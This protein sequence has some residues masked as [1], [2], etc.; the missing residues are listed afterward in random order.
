MNLALRNARALVLSASS[1]IG[2]PY[3]LA[4]L[5]WWVTFDAWSEKASKKLE[6]YEE[7]PEEFLY[8]L[9]EWVVRQ[10]VDQQSGA[11]ATALATIADTAE[12]VAGTIE[13]VKEVRDDLGQM[14]ADLPASVQKYVRP[15][16]D[17]IIKRFD[18]FY[19][20]TYTP[21]VE[22]LGIE[23]EQNRMNIERHRLKI[24]GLDLTI[25]K[26]PVKIGDWEAFEPAE[27]RRQEEIAEDTYTRP[28][29]RNAEVFTRVSSEETEKIVQEQKQKEVKIKPA[30]TPEYLTY[31]A[32]NTIVEFFRVQFTQVWTNFENMLPNAFEKLVDRFEDMLAVEGSPKMV[33]IMESLADMGAITS[34]DVLWI[35]DFLKRYGKGKTIVEFMLGMG[36]FFNY[37][38]LI[39]STVMS[40][41]A[42]DLNRK[43]RPALPDASSLLR[44]LFIAPE[45]SSGIIERLKKSGFSDEDIQYL[46]ISNYSLYDISMIRTL[47]LRGVLDE[48]RLYERMR[49]LGF[50]D[51]RIREIKES[52]DIIPPAQDI[53]HMV[54]KEAFE[55]DMIEKIGLGDEF[56]TEQVEWLKKQG[57]SEEWARRY[58]YAHWDQPS[59]QMGFEMLHRGIITWEELDMLFRAVEIPPFWRR[60]LTEMAYNPYTRVDTR[61][62][63]QLGIL[64]EQE[65]YESYLDQGYDEEKALK[66]TQFTIAY[67]T[68]EPKELTRTQIEQG[69]TRKLIDRAE[70]VDLLRSIGYTKDHAEYLLTL[71][72]YDN[73]MK[74]QERIIQRIGDRYKDNLI[75]RD[76]ALDLLTKAGTPAR[77][78]GELLDDWDVDRQ[79]DVKLHSK[80][81]L[82]KMYINKIINEDTYRLEMKKIGYAWNQIDRY[83]ELMKKTKKPS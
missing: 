58:W 71:K 34:K 50:T 29:Q 22:A 9:D 33:R 62:M 12:K 82:G 77:R 15:I 11:A 45:L 37:I 13:D 57:L 47:Y 1:T 52:F 66:M 27:R 16:T 74:Q 64:S 69:Y 70:A 32:E 46:I 55:P 54:A 76:Q 14:I 44:A 6:R 30:P 24:E 72:D 83:L 49:E 42:Q 48:A 3:D 20:D 8:D 56:P 36:L 78:I 31:E 65:V 63:Y 38:S 60:K 80:T 28:A 7:N 39:Q 81:D 79:Q 19:F 25:S 40:K 5:D 51:T 4:D 17:P 68:E 43:Y 59:I 2:R 67:V 53:L 18:D 75:T 26:N 73:A 10:S 21:A 41:T 23:A 61:R 35:R